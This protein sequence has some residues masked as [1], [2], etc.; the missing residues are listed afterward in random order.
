MLL[1]AALDIPALLPIAWGFRMAIEAIPTDR[2]PIGLHCFARGSCGDA[3]LLLGAYLADS[4]VGGFAYGCGE[5]GVQAD[6]SWTSHAGLQ[7]GDGVIDITADQFS[8]AP[9]GIVV[10]EPSIGHRQFQVAKPQPSDFRCWQGDGAEILAPMYRPILGQIDA[11]GV[12]SAVSR[13]E[14]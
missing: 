6:D 9:A 3:S 12:A 1:N 14:N 10:A 5:R 7:C 4:K 8:D 2:R 13:G 11:F